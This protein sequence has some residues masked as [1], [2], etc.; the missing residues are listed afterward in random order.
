MQLLI[1]LFLLPPLLNAG[2]FTF[3]TR[4]LESLIH[5]VPKVAPTFLP[6]MFNYQLRMLL[7]LSMS[8]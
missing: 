4:L 2:C 7:P 8:I 6:A 3:G 5:T 1:T